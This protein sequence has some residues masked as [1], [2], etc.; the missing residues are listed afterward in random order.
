MHSITL[1]IYLYGRSSYN[2]EYHS[3]KSLN[4]RTFGVSPK[5]IKNFRLKAFF[6]NVRSHMAQIKIKNA[7]KYYEFVVHTV[8]IY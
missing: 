1:A 4:V 5:T 2:H 7:Y 3:T 6:L 8:L